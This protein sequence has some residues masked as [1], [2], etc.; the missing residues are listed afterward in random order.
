MPTPNPTQESTPTIEPTQEPTPIETPVESQH[1]YDI[2]PGYVKIVLEADENL[3]DIKIEGSMVDGDKAGWETIYDDNVN[4]IFN[5]E[6]YRS[7]SLNLD[8]YN[9]PDQIKD[10]EEKYG[11][12][13][14]NVVFEIDFKESKVAWEVNGK[15]Y[16][17]DH[18]EGYDSVHAY[19]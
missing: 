12:S 17:H 6:T 13:I 7:D 8:K 5:R 2:N 9:T 15:I 16:T 1:L 11:G 3:F 19:L 10:L 4:K 14:N 18:V